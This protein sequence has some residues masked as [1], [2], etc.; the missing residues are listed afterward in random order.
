MKLTPLTAMRVRDVSR[1]Q[2]HHEA[3][4]EAEVAEWPPASPPP[5]APAPPPGRRG[6]AAPRPAKPPRP[7]A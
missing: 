3:Q 7:T 4:A 2:P 6:G 5:P 1:P